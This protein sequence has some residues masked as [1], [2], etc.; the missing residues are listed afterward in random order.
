[1]ATLD[2]DCALTPVRLHAVRCRVHL[3]ED[4]WHAETTGPQSSHIL[5]SLRGADAIALIPAGEG[6]LAA[7]SRV[8]IELLES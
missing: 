2:E 4:G 3:E 5:S 6:T 8:E 1:M 7:G